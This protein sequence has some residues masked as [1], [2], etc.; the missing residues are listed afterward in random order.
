MRAGRQRRI[1]IAR[2]AGGER[3]TRDIGPVAAVNCH[4]PDAGHH[5]RDG[6]PPEIGGV[7]EIL[8]D[9]PGNVDDRRKT[10]MPAG[11]IVKEPLEVVVVRQVWKV[12]QPVR[13]ELFED[14]LQPGVV[15]LHQLLASGDQPHQRQCQ[16]ELPLT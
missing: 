11:L 13:A 12:G 4:R 15:D 5:P 8:H 14:H 3:D 16:Q 6:V 9:E 1:R 7:A 2:R 10:E